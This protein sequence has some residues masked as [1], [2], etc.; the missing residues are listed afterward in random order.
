[1]SSLDE[2]ISRVEQ[3]VVDQW[4]RVL[5]SDAIKGWEDAG[6]LR[7][8]DL[9]LCNNSFLFREGRSTSKSAQYLGG[10]LNGSGS[11]EVPPVVVTRARG[12]NV[13]F[14][15]VGA[16][17]LTKYAVDGIRSA[18]AQ[19]LSGMGSIIFSLVGRIGEPEPAE[20]SLS[21]VSG[22]ETLAYMPG[23]TAEVEFSGGAI[24]L[25]RLADVDMAWT[26]T[27][28]LVGDS[29]ID[30]DA[31]G[32]PFEAAFHALQE[33][34]AR[35]VDPTDVVDDASSIIGGVL[36]RMRDQASTF[37]SDLKAHQIKPEDNEVYNDLL[38]VAY[39]FADGTR[40]FLGLVV[41]ICDLKPLIFWLT[42]FEQIQLAHCF[43]S[44]PFSL[45][46]KSKPSLDR[47]RSV[48][49]D[50]R[51]QAFHD[52]FAFDH[53]F[54]V[55]LAGDAIRMP[56]LNLFREYSARKESALTYQDR[57][58][59]ELFGGFSRTAQRPV[60]VGF[61]EGNQRVMDAVVEV[62]ESLRRALVI[63]AP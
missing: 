12:M 18:I 50:A 15:R 3:A 31:L 14:K 63:V 30:L 4:R 36:E 52:L 6:S 21:G 42:A 35:R 28:S 41:G 29:D 45:V 43:A 38:R 8:G 48:I 57:G 7:A 51:N 53:P 47:Y 22:V 58:L 27:R 24:S 9:L 37:S 54:R 34:A 61:W 62:V 32:D 13:Q 39:N 25:A 40:A 2:R 33:A 49:A 26:Q 10:R 23:Q 1:M 20:V 46:G 55:Q 17:E 5:A 11:V 56:E 59:V 44:L 60:P 16:K 19:E